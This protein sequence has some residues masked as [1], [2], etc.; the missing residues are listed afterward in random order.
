MEEWERLAADV[1]FFFRW[2]PKDAAR[3][4]WKQLQKWERQGLRIKKSL[5]AS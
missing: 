3:M 1:T 4:T 2:G 5:E